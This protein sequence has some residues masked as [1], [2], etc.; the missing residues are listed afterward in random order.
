VSRHKGRQNRCS[1][2]EMEKKR[3]IQ[4]KD[5][6][7]LGDL[8][9]RP[10]KRRRDSISDFIPFHQKLSC[11]SLLRNRLGFG[12]RFT[13][14]DNGGSSGGTGNGSAASCTKADRSRRCEMKTKAGKSLSGLLSD[15]S[16]NSIPLI[17]FVVIPLSDVHRI[18]LSS[19]LSVS[20]IR[21]DLTSFI[22]PLVV[23]SIVGVEV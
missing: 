3:H 12:F 2:S 8:V 18:S 13:I 14:G 22:F 11:F 10:V 17:L 6:A 16:N 19:T 9:L 1:A 20:F 5:Q 7:Y 21:P 4:E 23:L 15:R